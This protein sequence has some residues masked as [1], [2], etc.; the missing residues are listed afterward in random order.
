MWPPGMVERLRRNELGDDEYFAGLGRLTR[1]GKDE[2]HRLRIKAAGADADAAELERLR[3]VNAKRRAKSVDHTALVGHAI[4][5]YDQLHE[6]IV[7]KHGAVG[8]GKEARAAVIDII[9]DLHGVRVSDRT[10][11]RALARG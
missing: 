5:F 6:V 2:I 4:G 10:I 9:E 7:E 11:Q 3:D 8:A 1:A